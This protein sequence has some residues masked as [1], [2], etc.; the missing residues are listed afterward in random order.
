MKRSNARP[1]A[2]ATAIAT[3]IAG[4]TAIRFSHRDAEPVQS[5]IV[6]STVV[7]T[8]AP[9]AMN[10]PWPKLSTSIRPNTSVSPEAITKMISPMASPAMVSVSQLESDPTNGITTRAS[11]GTR[12]SGIQ[13]KPRAW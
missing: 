13:S 7:A 6:A 1:T 3:S 5:P 12:A 4:N 9:S 2:P 8:K 11:P 10:S